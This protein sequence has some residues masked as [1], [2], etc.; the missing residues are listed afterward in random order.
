MKH[1]LAVA[2]RHSC[3]TIVLLVLIASSAVACLGIAVFVGTPRPVGSALHMQWQG[4]L[5][6][7]HSRRQ[8]RSDGA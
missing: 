6:D 2:D 8:C 7:C 4:P 5:W 1:L 3:L